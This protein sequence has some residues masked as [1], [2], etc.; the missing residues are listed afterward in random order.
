MTFTERWLP[1]VGEV[2]Q[3]RYHLVE[4]I[5]KG[6]TG[7]VFKGID[8]ALKRGVAVKVLHPG[9]FEAD[10][11]TINAFRVQRARAFQHP[12]I[13][14]YH[15][16]VVPEDGSPPFFTEDLIEGLNLRT[17]QLLRAD[18]EE[19]LSPAEVRYVIEGVASALRWIHQLGVHGN[20]KPEN[21]F[22]AGEVVKVTDP[23]F[24]VGRA[25]VRWASGTDPL[26]DHYLAPEQLLR[27]QEETRQSD[28]FALGLLLGELTAGAT[29]RSGLPLSAQ[30]ADVPPEL[31]ELFVKA[32]ATDPVSR[33]ASVDSF[34]ADLR[35]AFPMEGQ[36]VVADLGDTTEVPLADVL[37]AAEIDAIEEV[38]RAREAERAAD[39]QPPQVPGDVAEAVPVAAVAEAIDVAEEAEDLPW[40]KDDDV[41]AAAARTSSLDVVPAVAED[42]VTLEWD[43]DIE[44]SAPQ[45]WLSRDGKPLH[46][47]ESLFDRTMVD[48][49]E[50]R[51][52]RLEVLRHV[53]EAAAG[54]VT[55]GAADAADTG[56]ADAA[57]PEAAEVEEEIGV[58]GVEPTGV[59]LELAEAVRGETERTTADAETP[60]LPVDAVDADD[61]VDDDAVVVIDVSD[62]DDVDDVDD[63]DDADDVDDVDDGES[64]AVPEAPADS[65]DDVDVDDEENLASTSM[66][67]VEVLA[68]EVDDGEDVSDDLVIEDVMEVGGDSEILLDGD[69]DELDLVDDGETEVAFVTAA[70]D[71]TETRTIERS[72]GPSPD[73]TIPGLPLEAVDALPTSK[74]ED[75]PRRRVT[76]ERPIVPRTA[77]IPQP[78]LDEGDE[79]ELAHATAIPLPPDDATIVLQRPKLH[80]V[81]VSPT[82]AALAEEEE[83][84][85]LEGDEEEPILL[86]GD[87]E[88]AERA[89][90]PTER[91][92][93]TEDATL[94]VGM[95]D[96]MMVPVRPHPKQ[97]AIEA[98]TAAA[99]LSGVP[100]GERPVATLAEPRKKASSGARWALAA[101]ILVVIGAAI[102]TAVQYGNDKGGKQ[103]TETAQKQGEHPQGVAVGQ[104]NSDAG[105]HAEAAADGGAGAVAAADVA[106][107]DAG[108]VAGADAGNTQV[109][110]TDA[111]H[112]G[113]ATVAATA[114]D[115]A[116]ASTDAGQ[117]VAQAGDGTGTAGSAAG[118]EADAKAADE[119]AAK[120]AEEAAAKKAADEAVA[121]KAADEAA[122]QLAADE[123]AKKAAD[124]A[125]A[126]KAADELAAKKAVDDAAAKKLADEAAAKKA[127]ELAAKK[128][129]EEEAKKLLTPEQIA[130]NEAKAK[131]LAEERKAKE[132]E[133]KANK[134]QDRLAREEAK[135]QKEEERKAKKE[136]D[137]LAREEAK[138]QKEEAKAS[139]NAAVVAS[140]TPGDDGGDTDLKCPA[141][142]RKIATKT[143]REIAGHKVIEKG[144]FC[145]EPYE[146]PGAGQKPRV[147][148]DWF[149]ANKACE[150]RGRRLCSS[151]EWK[152]A[153]GGKYP[154]GKTYDSAA[155]NTMGE[156]GEERDIKP[157]GSMKRCKSP[158]G[159]YD[160]SGNV[161]E[162][163]ADKTVN[164]GN[165]VNDDESATCG[166][167]PKRLESSPASYV[168]FRCCADPE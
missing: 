9:F 71:E 79:G 22:L 107:R 52:L 64:P 88:P 152:R 62:A 46:A 161:S 68:G 76:D 72:W 93:F 43:E 83:G 126:K 114:V 99:T 81:S 29:V 57:V 47:D 78:A 132:E 5:G 42:E 86:A 39:W 1:P 67:E 120:A 51:E 33:Y 165:S 95:A 113:D 147:N 11:R 110:A 50:D 35:R 77:A 26:S 19:P 34:L 16:I 118:A 157:A 10:R 123:A 13:V 73:H 90:S 136:Q 106:S 117:Q 134:E 94:D 148:V 14:A 70:P 115:T 97:A 160:M 92:S 7:A 154:Y 55:P 129:A 25:K 89:G 146:F 21:I 28:I 100:G 49:P 30:A 128:A 151:S 156:N 38:K 130:A 4:F 139:K 101:G 60:E 54:I 141:G 98:A 119:A 82:R 131:V 63:A 80:D 109:A 167:S 58:G 163:T 61:A 105:S 85:L 17:V 36:R 162:W 153:C 66:I 48:S 104:A 23:Y 168:G 3:G 27:A 125:A 59:E 142:M 37:T 2:L 140:A 144:A 20:L 74:E 159:I 158:Y 69:F 149:G 108:Q 8:L 164:G 44:T 18:A 56:A 53:R 15:D 133:R 91:P 112:A 137:R 155:C 87:E 103:A 96:I 75:G 12:N 145:I 65:G 121:K 102:F 122:A 31:D 111:G 6:P 32:T 127:E 138:R 116:V 45:A 135:R 150:G 40:H 124:E 84:I 166:R 41:Q 143:T 24:L